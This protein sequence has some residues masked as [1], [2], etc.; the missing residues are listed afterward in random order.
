MYNSLAGGETL[1]LIRKYNY[2]VHTS[3]WISTLEYI[4]EK[5]HY[6]PDIICD[7]RLQTHTFCNLPVHEKG[8]KSILNLYNEHRNRIKIQ[9]Q[10]PLGRHIFF[11]LI[12]IMTKADESKIDLSTYYVKIV[13]HNE[14]FNEI[15]D[16]ISA[17]SPDL[18]ERI[19]MF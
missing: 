17:I 1:N 3:E 14:L 15:M 11:E 7:V 8:G 4:T 19:K 13:H 18:K 2:C 5:L 9:Q 16:H 6:R 12:R 10:T